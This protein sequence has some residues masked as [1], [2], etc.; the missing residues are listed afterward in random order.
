MMPRPR[1]RLSATFVAALALALLLIPARTRAQAVALE[2]GQPRA[3][4]LATGDTLRYTIQAGDDYLLFGEVNQV[5][6]DVVV[7]IQNAEGQRLGQWDGP[8]RGAEAFS[9]TLREAGAYTILVAPFEDEEGDF[10]ITVL[11]LEAKSDD[12][13]TLAD[14]LMFAY[15]RPGGPGGAVQVW[16]DG[17]TVFSR[18]YGLADLAHGIPFDTKTPTNIGSTSKQFTAFAV[19]LEQERGNLS[20]DDDI[21]EYFPDFPDFGETITIR[22]LL[23]HTSGLREFLN[24]YGLTGWDTRSL[25]R[26]DVLRAVERQ[27]ALQNA[28]GGEFN[29]NNTA[30]SLAAQI[31]EKTSGQDFDDYMREHVFEPLEMNDSYVRMTPSSVIPRRSEGYTPGGDG[32]TAPGDLGGAVGAGGIYASVED[33]QRWGQNL[34][35]PRVGTPET[36][37]AML[38]EFVLNDGKGSGYGLGLFVDEQRGLKRAHHGGA[39]V[40]H[41]SMLV[42]YP[43][44]DAGLTVQ[45]NASTFNSGGTA[46][47]LGAAWF[48]D[49]MEPEEA[50]APAAGEPFDPA[51]Y[52]LDDFERV[53][54]SYSLDPQPQVVARFWRSGDTLYTQLT[55]QPA[56]EIRPSGPNRF[57]LVAVPASIV[58][59]DGDPA[60]GFTLYQGG[61]EIHASRMEAEEGQAAE[62]EPWK[63]TAEEL[64]A[65]TGRYFSDEIETFY[66][67]SLQHPDDE[68]EGEP[69]L[70]V[71]QLRRGDMTLRPTEKDTFVGGGMTLAFERDRRGIVIGLYVDV[72]RTRDVRFERVW[73]G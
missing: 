6:V 72:A 58:F 36:M 14:Q 17:R 7:S 31:V 52:D 4:T 21:R 53:A 25:T 61:Q 29:Y 8:G 54:G 32:W 1:T 68:P 28:P 48:G 43:G 20:L 33:L 2:V 35:S 63:P 57:D 64:E 40:S 62:H 24:L 42:H 60:P 13:A 19:L 71:S 66:T 38:T 11:Q 9:T 73:G 41:R 5:S 69:R 22:N 67:V 59:E 15:A 30:F 39:D 34:L 37:E 12:P 27:P 56:L 44:I 49:A 46:F 65:F 18:A 50:A 51:T 47:D 55:G 10:E 45:S 26:D 70:V 16:R 23:T 3:G